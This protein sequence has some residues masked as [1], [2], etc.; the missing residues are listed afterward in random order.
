MSLQ[1]I[2]HGKRLHFVVHQHQVG[3]RERKKRCVHLK[4]LTH[5][6]HEWHPETVFIWNESMQSKNFEFLENHLLARAP[7]I[8]TSN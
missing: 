4:G 3:N 5:E 7:Y 2:V 6:E 8:T 1:C